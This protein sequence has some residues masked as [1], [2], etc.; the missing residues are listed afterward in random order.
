[1]SQ[2]WDKYVLGARNVT[3]IQTLRV[4]SLNINDSKFML[5]SLQIVDFDLV[6]IEGKGL[7]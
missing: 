4:D 2:F 5:M 1:M 7:N 6:F 3:I